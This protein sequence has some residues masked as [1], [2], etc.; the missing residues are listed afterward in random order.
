MLATGCHMTVT[1]SSLLHV[2]FNPW[3]GIF[4]YIAECPV[5]ELA[6]TTWAVAL[7]HA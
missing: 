6:V 5:H 3:S 7:P 4:V 2:L 1:D